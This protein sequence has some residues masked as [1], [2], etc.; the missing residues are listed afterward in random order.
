MSN[1]SQEEAAIDQMLKAM[2]RRWLVHDVLL[3]AL[4]RLWN[5]KPTVIKND[6]K[7]MGPMNCELDADGILEA[8]EAAVLMIHHLFKIKAGLVKEPT[9][10]D[11]WKFTE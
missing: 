2:Q 5:E 9:N 4:G 1:Q 7:L 10:G 11:E 6:V 8:H 3:E